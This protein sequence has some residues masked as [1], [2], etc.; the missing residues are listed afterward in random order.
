MQFYPDHDP[1]LI[2]TNQLD[3]MPYVL[4]PSNISSIMNAAPKVVVNAGYNSSSFHPGKLSFSQR[5]EQ[6]LLEMAHSNPETL[7]NYFRIP[8]G[9]RGGL[10]SFGELHGDDEGGQG[11]MRSSGG[12]VPGP[13]FGAFGIS[14]GR[15][16]APAST[17]GYSSAGPGQPLNSG[18]CG[19]STTGYTSGGP[20]QPLS[21]PSLGGSSRGRGRGNALPTLHEFPRTLGG[22]YGSAASS[23]AAARDAALRRDAATKVEQIRNKAEIKREACMKEIR[24]S[25]KTAAKKVKLKGQEAQKER[26]KQ[27]KVERDRKARSRKERERGQKSQDVRSLAAEAAARRDV[28]TKDIQ[29]ERGEFQ[30]VRHEK[31]KREKEERA[32]ARAAKRR[33]EEEGEEE[34]KY[35]LAMENRQ[36]DVVAREVKARNV[37]VNF[38]DVRQLVREAAERRFAAIERERQVEERSKNSPAPKKDETAQPLVCADCA[39]RFASESQ[40]SAHA[41][42]SGH[43]NYAEVKLGSGK[44]AVKPSPAPAL[45]K[46]AAPAPQATLAKTAAEV[47]EKKT[48]P[49]RPAPAKATAKAALLPPA[50]PIE[51][52]EEKLTPRERVKLAMARREAAIRALPAEEQEVVRR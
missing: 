40:A 16:Q 22:S 13:N 6:S 19:G 33:E 10:K 8:P 42:K 30:R 4:Q 29:K 21:G 2:N 18:G 48:L 49:S 47:P 39:K 44:S 26:V 15:G 24:Q 52:D 28:A 51:S 41:D 45:V 46:E 12:T 17:S 5:W 27:E 7:R 36:R 38:K 43:Q 23:R 50:S 9:K 37:E 3:G 1:D 25:E 32:R 11:G 14:R 34:G 20:G 31:E 35:R